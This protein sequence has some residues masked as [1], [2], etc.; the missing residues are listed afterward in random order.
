MVRPVFVEVD[1]P[2]PW[3]KFR[4][5]SALDRRLRELLDRQ[6]RDGKLTPRERQEA[7][8]LVELV[9]ILTLMKART[10]QREP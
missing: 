4:L 9:D 3:R 2:Q 8:A 1:L 5:P 10:K 6:D 7:E